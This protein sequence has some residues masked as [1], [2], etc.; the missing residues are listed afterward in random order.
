M[1][2]WGTGVFENDTACDFAGAVAT[3][4]DLAALEAT[5]DR[6][7]GAGDDYLEAPDAEEALAAADIVTRLK[8]RARE[9]TAYTTEIDEWVEQSKFDPSADLVEKAR[10]AIARILKEPSELLELWRDS[11][12]FESW[13]HSVEDLS[14]HL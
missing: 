7:L 13:R 4:R 9:R 2:A 6:V 5:F 10:L 3:S 14:R 11:D 8:G 12:E 1:G